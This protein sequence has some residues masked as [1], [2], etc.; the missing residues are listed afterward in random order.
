MV[1]VPQSLPLHVDR[2]IQN[3]AARAVLRRQA[4]FG[5]IFA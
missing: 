5:I 3:S 2:I 4:F 1:F